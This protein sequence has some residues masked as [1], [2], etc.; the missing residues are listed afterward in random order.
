[1]NFKKVLGLVVAAVVVAFFVIPDDAVKTTVSVVKRGVMRPSETIEPAPKFTSDKVDG[2]ISVVK[3]SARNTIVFRGPV[4]EL[5]VSKAQQT[6]LKMS[7]NLSSKDTIYMVLD[8]PGGSVSAGMR[9]IDTIRGI[10]Q[11]VKTITQ[12]AASMGFYF[13]Q[14]LDERLVT[15]SGTL[16]AHRA[17]MGGVSGEIPG[18]VLVRINMILDILRSM[19][20]TNANRL[21]VTLQKYQDVIRDEYWVS[22][23]EAVKQNAADRVV[24]IQCDESLDGTEDDVAQTPFGNIII[25]FAKCPAITSALGAFGERARS[26]TASEEA[27]FQRL[28][29]EKVRGS[30]RGF[31]L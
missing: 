29:Q 14:A 28:I 23:V 8:T 24:A 3:L 21:G 13:V 25:Q 26:L 7:R 6:L 22:G 18:E 11:K 31:P 16:M 19:E 15:P 4:D 17:K 20:T 1:M 12:F 2:G 10:P 5:S 30:H 27:E 9:L